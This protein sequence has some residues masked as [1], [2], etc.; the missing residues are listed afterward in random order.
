VK[1]DDSSHK[2]KF[3]EGGRVDCDQADQAEEKAKQKSERESD[4]T[5]QGAG[6]KR[7]LPPSL[8]F[9]DFN[10]KEIPE[11]KTLI[12]GILTVGAK[13][14]IN[15]P[16]KAGKSFL[17]V[18]LAVS[19]ANGVGWLGKRVA[20]GKVFYVNFEL[21]KHYFRER[22]RK[23]L[24]TKG[25]KQHQPN[26]RVWNLRGYYPTVTDFAEALLAEIGTEQY[27]IIIIDPF[28][29]LLLG[30]RENDPGDMAKVLAV[31]E[32]IAEKSGAS[33]IYAGH[34]SK[35][36][37]TKKEAQDRISGS[38]VLARD[39]DVIFTMTSCKGHRSEDICY[40]VEI[41]LRDFKAPGKFV[42]RWDP[43]ACLFK[44]DEA[45]DPEELKKPGSEKKFSEEMLLA[46][47]GDEELTT[48]D[49]EKRC[50]TEYGMSG[51]TFHN[52]M[53]NLRKAKK[54]EKSNLTKR[55]SKTVSEFN[56]EKGYK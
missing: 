44:P 47:L 15:G 53:A 20:P 8:S 28:Y 23:I 36:D 14:S 46:E 27:D 16:S 33:L 5:E 11:P 51:R 10:Q 17:L 4:G 24:A 55:W 3:D 31:F 39:P 43:D 45:L 49:W 38:G 26:L 30:A 29:K 21:R 50:M 34:F 2:S 42:I 7:T 9:N 48:K 40:A 12:N 52:L 22:L 25:V 41:G 1:N 32:Q 19:V 13:M 37:Q 54:I 6:E 18:D 56:R 35:G